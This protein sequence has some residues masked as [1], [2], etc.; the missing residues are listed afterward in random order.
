MDFAMLRTKMDDSQLK[1]EGVIDPAVL[2]AFAAVP[3]ERFVPARLKPLAYVDSDLLI[4][5]ADGSVTG[6]YLM[7]PAPLARLIQA[8][9]IQ[10]TDTVLIIGAG[11]GYSAAVA[12]RLARGVA[13]VES[14]PALAEEA[15]R[16]L[17]A[18]AV[19][20]ATVIIAPLAAGYPKGA[21]YDVIII[22]GAVEVVPEALF[23]QLHEGGRLVTIVGLGR[24]AQGTVYTRTDDEIGSRP[25][26]N[27]G[28]HPL[29]GFERPAAFVF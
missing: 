1:T 27:A 10:P 20:N 23:E 7:Q 15:T 29:P 14:D 21:P 11:T 12:A 16:T 2:N 13:A 17:A 19:T 24:A 9:A 26:F 8:A 22:E 4:K 25:V 6:R 18:L 3:R 5:P 28:V